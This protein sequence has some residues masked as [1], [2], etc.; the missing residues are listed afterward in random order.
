MKMKSTEQK[1]YESVSE[2]HVWRLLRTTITKGVK[3]HSL[4]HYHVLFSPQLLIH[5]FCIIT[6]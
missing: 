3:R 5:Q 1:K 4:P 2:L 6:V